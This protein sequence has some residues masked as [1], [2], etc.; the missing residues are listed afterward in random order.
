VV[1]VVDDSQPLRKLLMAQLATLGFTPLEA[2]SGDAALQ[3]LG[4]PSRVDVLLTDVM[5]PDD[6]DGRKLARD[7]RA[8]RPTIKVILTSGY[9]LPNSEAGSEAPA[10][11]HLRKPF[12]KSDLSKVLSAVLD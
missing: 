8:L 10:M 6:V 1:L 5:M 9:P 4:S 11:A 12:S 2:P 3:I 7:A